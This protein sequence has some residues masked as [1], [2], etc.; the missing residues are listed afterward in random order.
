MTATVQYQ[1]D[2]SRKAK[3][4]ADVLTQA[5]LASIF[6]V[7]RS[8]VSR[9]VSGEDTPRGANATAVLDLDF[10]VARYA[11]AFPTATFHDW[12]MA[13]NAFLNSA[14]PKDVLQLEGPGRVIDALSSEIAGS[15]A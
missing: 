14:T 7:S 12:F 8:S 15:F 3:S 5:G 10:I 1:Q 13:P 2:L 11:L 4:L 6:D 9:W